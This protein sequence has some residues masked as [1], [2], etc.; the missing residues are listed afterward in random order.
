MDNARVRALIEA[1]WLLCAS[2]F[3]GLGLAGALHVVRSLTNDIDNHRTIVFGAFLRVLFA[4][5]LIVIGAALIW[6][7][8][9]S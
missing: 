6:S 1:L 8:L 4:A 7:I 2:G 3:L 9:N 5:S